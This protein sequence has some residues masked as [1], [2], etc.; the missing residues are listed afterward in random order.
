MNFNQKV[1]E[2]VKRIPFGKVASYGQVAL[3]LNNPRS[4]R[5]V[6]WALHLLDGKNDEVPWWRVV[7]KKGELTIKGNLLDTANIQRQLLIK[8]GVEV[9]EVMKLD[10]EKYRYRF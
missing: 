3:L 7:N 10:I 6:G 9:N 5:Q 8:E 4:A 2:A 1:Y